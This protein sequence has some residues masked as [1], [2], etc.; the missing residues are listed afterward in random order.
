MKLRIDLEGCNLQEYLQKILS[1]REYSFAI[2]ITAKETVRDIKAKVSCVVLVHEYELQQVQASPELKQNCELSSGQVNTNSS[3][4]FG[5]PEV[6]FKSDFGGLEKEG[7]NVLTSLSIM[8][9]DVDNRKDLFDS[10]VC[11][12]CT[13]MLQDIIT[14]CLRMKK[15]IDTRFNDNYQQENTMHELVKS[16]HLKLNMMLLVSENAQLWHITPSFF[17]LFFCFVWFF[18]SFGVKFFCTNCQKK[19]KEK[20]EELLLK[21][22]SILVRNVDY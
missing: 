3:E 13:T 6:L 7:I 22:S 11:S 9:C 5:C 19:N 17:F 20:E 2:L 10:N 21:R 12:G 8:K 16:G 15:I 18:S 1:E 4:R 14:G